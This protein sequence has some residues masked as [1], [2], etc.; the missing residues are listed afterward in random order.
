MA[1]LTVD[2]HSDVLGM[3]MT[4]NVILPQAATSAI[5]IASSDCSD[6]KT[7]YLLHGLSDDHTIWSR[8]TSIERYVA[9]KNLAVVM[10]CA[11]K[12]WYTDMAV[13]DRYFEYISKEIPSICRSMFRQMSS[14][15]ED[16]F[17]AG[18]S[19]GG[20]GAVKTALTYPESFAGCAGLS[21]AYDIEKRYGYGDD[22]YR[23]MEAIFGPK[24]QFGNSVNNVYRLAEKLSKSERVKPRIFLW[25]GTEDA[26][27]SDTRK[28]SEILDDGGY[29]FTSSSS[30]GAHEWLSWD[31][32]I[33]NAIEFFGI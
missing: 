3:G 9:G 24:E 33:K 12:S 8:R 1:F 11:H 28:L 4:M 31:R 5:G 6:C 20:Y 15:R 25:C 19:M 26:L 2:F 22:E 13:G 32:E 17:I 14:A 29:E 10:P 23:R 27:L 16:N 21:G 7:L 18:L 30:H